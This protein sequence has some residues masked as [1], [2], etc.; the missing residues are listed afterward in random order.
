MLLKIVG[1]LSD[2]MVSDVY[3]A[4]RSDMQGEARLSFFSTTEREPQR[5]AGFEIFSTME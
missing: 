1:V 3:V 4:P 5:G 2:L